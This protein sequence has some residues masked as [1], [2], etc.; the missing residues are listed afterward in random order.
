MGRET[1]GRPLALYPKGEPLDNV[2]A[3]YI[4]RERGQTLTVAPLPLRPH[5]LYL[6][7]ENYLAGQRYRTLDRIVIDRN[8]AFRVV[9]F[10]LP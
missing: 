1:R 9:E 4:A 3:F 5:T 8:I 7:D 10:D 2:E 6:I